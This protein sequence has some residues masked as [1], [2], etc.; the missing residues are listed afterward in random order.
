[1]KDRTLALLVT[2]VGVGAQPQYSVLF[3]IELVILSCILANLAQYSR[4][5]D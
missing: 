2:G 5:V 1:M 3:I 4:I